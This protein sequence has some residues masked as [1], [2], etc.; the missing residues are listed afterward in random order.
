MLEQIPEP[1][2]IIPNSSV[3]SFVYLLERTR[4]AAGDQ[5]IVESSLPHGNYRIGKTMDPN[6]D[7]TTGPKWSCL[8]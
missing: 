6:E 1:H 7:K 5:E 8:W 3:R 2:M 4:N